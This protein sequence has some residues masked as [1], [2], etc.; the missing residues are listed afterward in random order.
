MEFFEHL[1]RAGGFYYERWGD[2]P[3]HS[4]GAALFARKDQIHW[5]EDIGYR[6]EPFQVSCLWQF[7]R[8]ADDQHCPQGDA[9]ERGKCWCDPKNNF[10]WEWY[11]L[12]PSLVLHGFADRQ[13][14][15][16]KQIHCAVPGSDC[17]TQ[18][19]ALVSAIPGCIVQMCRLATQ[20]IP[21]FPV[22]TRHIFAGIRIKSTRYTLPA[23]CS[24]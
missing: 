10:D 7:L 20:A 11:V 2:A 13:V 19:V 16:Y 15:V 9:H 17:G 8:R 12:L 6:H 21:W 14:L 4:I 24:S 5:F 18:D 1:D 23:R 22:F 3:V